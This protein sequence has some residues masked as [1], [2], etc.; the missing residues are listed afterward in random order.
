MIN[1]YAADYKEIRNSQLEAQIFY[2]KPFVK[3]ENPKRI[4]A[5]TYHLVGF[6]V[7]NGL[8]WGIRNYYYKA[9]SQDFLNA[10][11]DMFEDYLV[12][13]SEQYLAT[14][15][16]EHLQHENERITDFRYEFENCIWLVEQKSALLKLNAKSQTPNMK[17]ISIFLNRNIQKAYKQLE[18]TYQRETSTKPVL[19]FILLY[20]NLQN[21]Q[22]MQISMP[23]IFEN[24]S[25]CFIIGI[26]EFE[27]LL[28]IRKEDPMLWEKVIKELL[29]RKADNVSVTNILNRTE[30]FQYSDIFIHNNDY[31]QKY[32]DEM[33]DFY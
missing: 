22:L 19:K 30:G 7:A 20:E 16:F 11:G 15:E 14:N 18:A 2:T 29:S 13:L 27:Q 26:S 12:E 32:I 33:Q 17:N 5:V 23:E 8:Y 1:Y 28:R 31:V 3:T 24:D 25:R 21:T 6:L 4:L 10:F 9:D